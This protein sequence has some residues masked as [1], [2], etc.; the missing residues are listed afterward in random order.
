MVFVFYG[1]RWRMNIFG[2]PEKF[3]TEEF[4]KS[5]FWCA[6]RFVFAQSF[7]FSTGS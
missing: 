5:F 3:D 6:K 4:E 7:R 2:P 1:Y